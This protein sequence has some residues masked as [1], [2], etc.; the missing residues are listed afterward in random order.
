MSW[1]KKHLIGIGLAAA[2]LGACGSPAAYA[3]SGGEPVTTDTYS[4]F[5]VSLQ[6]GFPDGEG[7]S[8]HS[9]GGTMI[10]QQRVLTAAHC[11]GAASYAVFGS[12]DVGTGYFGPTVQT[13]RIVGAIVHPDYRP[14]QTP[15]AFDVAVLQLE[16]PFT[17][18]QPPVLPGIG[19]S[20]L[21]A[22]GTT[23]RLLGWGWLASDQPQNPERLQFVDHALWS[24]SDCA[25]AANGIDFH[26]EA[27]L[28]VSEAGKSACST[29]SGG[30]LLVEQ[31]GLVYQVGVV[32][33]A[34]RAGGKCGDGSRPVHY[35]NLAST[36][37]RGGLDLP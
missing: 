37:L 2:L 11:V 29:D 26:P 9:C 5:M 1:K 23:A 8:T 13:S 7:G 22:P 24:A 14:G 20:D 18:V 27:E 31:A 28:C 35:S 36:E 12:S 30:P 19:S 17:D 10:D 4:T 25:A 32:S 3:V 33:G 6:A 15:S 34:G 21:T 16:R